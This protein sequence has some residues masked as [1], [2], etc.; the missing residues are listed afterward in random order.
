LISYCAQDFFKC[1]KDK[2]GIDLKNVVYYRDETHYF[3]MTATKKSLIDKGV[4]K[5]VC[6]WLACVLCL[7]LHTS[8]INALC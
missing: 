5:E 4:L 6:T 1:M 8:L 7:F 2:H 3:V